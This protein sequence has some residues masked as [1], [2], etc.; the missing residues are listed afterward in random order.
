MQPGVLLLRTSNLKT[1]PSDS[2]IR[3]AI[4]EDIHEL[5]SLVC[6]LAN[7]ENL[8]HTVISTPT[9]LQEALF[10]ETPRAE[11]LVAETP[12]ATG[13]ESP[14]RLSGMAIFHPSFSTFTGR[15][16]LWL[17]DVYVRPEC[18]DAGIG[19]AFLER[20]LTIA[21]ERGCARAEWSVLDWNTPAIKFYER[22]GA[23]IM[24]DWRIARMDL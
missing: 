1:E 13:A 4:P 3:E 12:G 2:R 9:D 23:T 18:R 14:F 15:P 24:P 8:G 21:R 19:K 10:S 6:E 5:H 17:E 20:F 16:G 11:A 22:L 7:Y